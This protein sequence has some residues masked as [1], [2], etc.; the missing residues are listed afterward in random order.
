M[1]PPTNWCPIRA[2]KKCGAPI[3]LLPF[4]YG[5]NVVQYQYLAYAYGCN[6]FHTRRGW[7]R[8]STYLIPIRNIQAVTVH[9][10]LFDRRLGLATLK[11]HTAGQ[12]QEKQVPF[13]VMCTQFF[14]EIV[15]NGRTYACPNTTVETGACFIW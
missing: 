13:F 14:D 10:G 7:L 1:A 3:L 4:V 8:H 15:V 6:Y 2:R 12:K 5:Y 11:L 9:Q